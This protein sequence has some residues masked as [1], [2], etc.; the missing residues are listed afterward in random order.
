M[1]SWYGHDYLHILIFCSGALCCVTLILFVR[2]VVCVS[3]VRVVCLRSH[4]EQ[5]PLRYICRKCT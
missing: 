3:H 4:T 5:A 2:R 1:V